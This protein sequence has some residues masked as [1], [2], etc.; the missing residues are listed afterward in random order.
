[1]QLYLYNYNDSQH[2]ENIF[3]W[4]P[5]DKQ[6]W[7]TGFN[8]AYVN[9]VDVTKQVLIG[10]VNFSGYSDMYNALKNKTDERDDIKD[11]II[12]DDENYVVWI[13]WYEGNL[14]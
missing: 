1:M 2:I 5:D 13:I 3:S 10:C 4:R 7:I 9:N 14:V 6:W 8:P 11:Y 12:F